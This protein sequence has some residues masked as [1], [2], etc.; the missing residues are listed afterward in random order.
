MAGQDAPATIGLIVDSSASMARKWT[1]VQRAVATFAADSN[2]RDE[3]FVIQFSD[4]IQWPL[5]QGQAF[6]N[7]AEEIKTAM[8][9]VSPSGRTA[10]YDAIAAG[11]DHLKKGHCEKKILVILSDGADNGSVEGFEELLAAAQQA[12]VTLYT[13]GLYEP[14]AKDRNP[15]VLKRLAAV[16]GGE[17]YFPQYEE[18]LQAAWRRIAGGVRT[19]Y[20]IGYYP[21]KPGDGTF[22]K[23]KVSAKSPGGS[24]L[25]VHTRPGYFARKVTVK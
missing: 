18:E 14:E 3:M 12:S 20:T 8:M 11:F 1:E 19:Q 5:P 7:D 21:Q 24:K 9:K 17:A 25:S 13:I 15:K 4:E 16:S 10:L 23:I 2:P 6:T 22:R